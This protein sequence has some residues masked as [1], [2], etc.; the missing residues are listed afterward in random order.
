MSKLTELQERI[1][2][3]VRRGVA[4]VLT[5]HKKLGHSIVVLK[6]GKVEQEGQACIIVF[7]T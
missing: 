3:G 1:D 4:R 6:D 2:L 5:E 7:S